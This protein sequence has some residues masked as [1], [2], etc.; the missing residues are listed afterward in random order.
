MIAWADG[1]APGA[2]RSAP[3]RPGT[4]PKNP[5]KRAAV[6]HERPVTRARSRTSTGRRARA[7]PG[8]GDPVKI[9]IRKHWRDFV[10]ILGLF[11]IAG[12]SR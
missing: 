9:A 11:L 4:R 12:A 2:R 7:G 6:Q 8:E 3:S 5:G 1:S 10:A